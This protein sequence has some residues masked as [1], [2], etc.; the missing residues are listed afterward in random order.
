MGMIVSFALGTS[1]PAYRMVIAGYGI[2]DCWSGEML[3]LMMKHPNVY[4]PPPATSRLADY[5]RGPGKRKVLFGSNFAMLTVAQ[6]LEDVDQ[7][8][9]S[10]ETRALFLAE[11]RPKTSLLPPVKQHRFDPLM[12]LEYGR[13]LVAKRRKTFRGVDA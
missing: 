10:D 11:N 6:C 4:V 9:L 3:S 2:G 7:L 13:P 5:M 12:A 1:D 8:A